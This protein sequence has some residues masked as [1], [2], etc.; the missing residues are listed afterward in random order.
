MV[1][2][3]PTLENNMEA[4]RGMKASSAEDLTKIKLPKMV[5]PKI[6]GVR[7]IIKDGVVMS[8]NMKPIR[9]DFVQ[10]MFGHPE[11][12]GLDGELIVGLP[13]DHHSLRNTMSGISRITGECDVHFHVFDD[14]SL[15]DV[16]FQHR[17]EDVV[18]SVG[19]RALQDVTHGRL[20]L[21]EHE[22]VGNVQE[23]LDYEQAKLELG[24]EGIMI[25][26][27]EGPYKFGRSSPREDWLW[28]VK[29]FED[30]EAKIVGFEEEMRNDNV[31][32]TN[33]LGKAKRTSHKENKTAKGTLGGLLVVGTTGRYKDVPY[34]VGIGFDDATAQWIWDNQD[35]CLGKIIKV[36]YFPVGNLNKPAHTVFLDFRPEGM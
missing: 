17:Y 2:A 22:F 12:N 31:L 19:H 15:H 25:R 27:P 5:S 33:E 3:V 21:V 36:K 35:D 28:K 1:W 24:Y 30:A 29:R 11:L 13:T 16:R 34:R 8:Y 32:Q 14:Y 4:F 23:L 6:N 26:H 7:G 9:N 10:T 18:K 20:V